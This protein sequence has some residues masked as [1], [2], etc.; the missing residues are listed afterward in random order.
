MFANEDVMHLR[1]MSYKLRQNNPAFDKFYLP[2]NDFL[3]LEE[4]T[5]AIRLN[6]TVEEVSV[7]MEYLEDDW[8]VTDIWRIF[9]ALGNLPK[10][11][12]LVFDFIGSDGDELPLS[13]LTAAVR[14]AS[15][16]TALELS[17]V[18]L[19]GSED[20]IR[21]FAQSLRQKSWKKIEIYGCF[22]D[23]ETRKKSSLN[24]ILN[25]MASF[26]TLKDVTITALDFN[27]LGSFSGESLGRLI[28]QNQSIKCLVLGEFNLNDEH[29]VPMS[30]A[31]E[32]NQSLTELSIGCNLESKGTFAL[33]NMIR[34]NRTLESL[35]LDLTTLVDGESNHIALAESLGSNDKIKRFSIFGTKGN[36]TAKAQLRFAQML[37]HNFSL[38]EL[39]FQDED[40]DAS[41]SIEMYLTLNSLG[42]RDLL[43]NQ[44]TTKEDWVSALCNVHDNEAC[45]FYLL[46]LNPALC[47]VDALDT[48]DASEEEKRGTKRKLFEE[49]P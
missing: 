44:S 34:T 31:L 5:A 18:H 39:E 28:R 42:R 25:E 26:S 10:L 30:E 27:S 16:V 1:R 13:L 11:Q 3:N 8:L 19:A 33:A 7:F 48:T 38:E 15:K 22:L 14:P 29:I 4:I 43:H 49:A 46:S 2:L 24:P 37:E 47:N 23:P 17:C 21:R 6:E 45:I 40:E 35:H 9:R 12:R 32:E 20:D 41:P 36:I